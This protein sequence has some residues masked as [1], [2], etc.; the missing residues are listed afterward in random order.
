MPDKVADISIG[1]LQPGDEWLVHRLWERANSQS[2]GSIGGHTW[3]VR[4]LGRH[5]DRD[6][7]LALWKD[8]DL[9][10]VILYRKQGELVEIDLLATDPNHQNQGKML[11]LFQELIKK[12]QDVNEIWLELHESN[13]SAL[14]FYQKVGFQKVGERKD[15]Y[16]KGETAYLLSLTLS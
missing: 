11:A 7:S 4:S 15:Y 12:N 13:T 5:I 10:A 8:G 6:P 2:Q 1:N 14:A 3:G 16:G 9:C